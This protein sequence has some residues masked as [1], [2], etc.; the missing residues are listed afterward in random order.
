MDNRAKEAIAKALEAAQ[1]HSERVDIRK[2]GG[3]RTL[4]KER[5]YTVCLM[6]FT[7]E[8]KRQVGTEVHLD[9]RDMVDSASSIAAGIFLLLVQMRRV[10]YPHT[11]GGLEEK[12]I[13]GKMGSLLLSQMTFLLE[14]IISGDADGVLRDGGDPD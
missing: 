10:A 13:F 1:A 6:A 9:G 7:D 12:L 4:N 5:L 14:A 11:A 2:T 3:V 8:M